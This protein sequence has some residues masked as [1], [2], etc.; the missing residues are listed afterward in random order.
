RTQWSTGQHQSDGQPRIATANTAVA[1]KDA[2]RAHTSRSAPGTHKQ[3]GKS[4]NT[5]PPQ[6]PRPKASVDDEA[7]VPKTGPAHRH[8]MSPTTDRCSGLAAVRPPQVQHS[9][10]AQGAPFH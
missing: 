1:S 8:R 2:F 10:P 3:T 5:P 6:C 4:T 9:E 7:P